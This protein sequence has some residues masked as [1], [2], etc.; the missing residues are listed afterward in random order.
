M[1]KLTNE[2]G[3]VMVRKFLPLFITTALTLSLSA[4][5]FGNIDE[6]YSLPRHSETYAQLQSLID[7][8]LEAGSEFSAPASG[9]YRQSV[10]FQDVTGNGKEEALVFF[11]GVGQVPKICVYRAV[12]DEF[13]PATV[14]EGEGTAIGRVEY[15]DLD[16]DD[17]DE[18]IVA[19]QISPTLCTVSVYSM[20]EYS[21]AVLLNANCADFRVVDLRGLAGLMTIKRD[22]LSAFLDMYS[23][24]DAFEPAVTSARLSAGIENVERVRLSAL[25][26]GEPALFIDS[27][28]G[29]G[30][31][32]TDVVIYAANGGIKNIT[33]DMETGMSASTLRE[34]PSD[35]AYTQDIDGDKTVEIPELY[36]LY[37]QADGVSGYWVFDWYSFDS[38]GAKKLLCSTYHSGEGWYLVLPGSWRENLTVRREDL[39]AGERG[40][41]LSQ[42]DRRTRDVI[43]ILVI[44]TLTGENRGDRARLPGRFIIPNMEEGTTVFAA[45]ILSDSD[46]WAHSLT[47]EDLIGRVKPIRQEWG[48]EN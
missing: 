12:G 33:L 7:R 47:A 11:R 8:E 15:A 17:V 29:D 18:I 5:L 3:G 28:R 40:V 48:Y 16:G 13:E 10:Q 21:S 14:L 27:S 44:Y 22:D 20:R 37:S 30:K 42:V 9:S 24:N 26:D 43:D 25:S 19:W 41:I 23:F 34:K 45:R 39:V 4:C 1:W 31:L 36:R 35:N 32:V 2:R 38:T 46:V 6:L